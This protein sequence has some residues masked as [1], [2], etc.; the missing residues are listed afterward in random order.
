MFIRN[1]TNILKIVGLIMCFSGWLITS[2]V[3]AG[4]DEWEFN[5]SGY[6]RS[7]TG[8][9]LDDNDETQGNDTWE[10]NMARGTFLLDFDAYTGP[11]SWKLITRY[12][13]EHKTDYL[14]ELE[15]LTELQ[16]PG[17]TATSG[18]YLDQYQTDT[19]QEF[20]REYYVD[21]TPMKNVDMRIGKQ[22]LVWGESDFFQAMD[23]VHGFDYR[24]RLFFENNED[25]R[26]PLFLIN[27]VIDVPKY[28]GSLNT[29][30]RPGLDNK[31]AIGS[32]FN[33]EGGRWIPHPY[34]GVD[35]TAFTQYNAYENDEGDQD[36]PTYG[37]RWTGNAGSIGYSVAYMH[38]FNPA[39]IMNPAVNSG[40]PGAFGVT[41]MR[42]YG[43]VA[44]N[45][46]LGDWVYPIINVLGF[47]VNGYSQ[48]ID[49][50]L[51]AE[52]TWTPDK[53]FNF[54]NLESS[55]PGWGG[56]KERDT[57]AIMLRIDKELKLGKWLKTNRPSLSSIQLFD[58]W[59]VN[60]DKEDE[61]VEFASFGAKKKEHTAYLTLF[62]LL[63]YKRDTINP[64][65]VVGTD[66]SNG[67][68]FVIPALEVVVGDG[69]RFKAEANLWWASD[70]KE[71][72]GL[73]P[74]GAGDHL[75]PLGTPENKAS[76]FD[77]FASDNQLVFKVTRQY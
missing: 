48:K 17:G 24:W 15:R 53:P 75:N 74:G 16:S 13:L 21:F 3:Q 47:S 68:G 73:K 59:I 66:L 4:T 39:P 58:T 72:S 8:V 69:W 45:Q 40:V 18:R 7:Y 38:V 5:V 29:F 71:P 42:Q 50:T 70:E 43:N 44:E 64:S 28:N 23:L 63:N 41:S 9:L 27:T 67:G 46:V 36:D 65:L 30:V 55:L 14:S 54:G 19:V 34:R 76:F 2:P 11:L 1:Y 32:N 52:F 56:V 61:I 57:I 62:T 22:Q 33:I 20:F 49:S 60:H 25:W 35:F 26:K 10:I 6:L 77:W 37:A 31:E 12:D 51:S